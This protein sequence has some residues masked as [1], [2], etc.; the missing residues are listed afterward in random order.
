VTRYRFERGGVVL[1]VVTRGEW[2]GHQGSWH[3][4]GWLETAPGSDA[5]IELLTSEC[6][7]HDEAVR[8]EHDGSDPVNLLREA[9]GLQMKFMEPGVTL[10]SLM[11][12]ERFTLAETHTDGERIYWR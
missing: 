2:D 9:A 5:A 10:V 8:L 12:G 7:L 11:D 1:G 6:R 4:W 3:D